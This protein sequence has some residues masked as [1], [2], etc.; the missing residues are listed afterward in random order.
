MSIFDA[1]RSDNRK[2]YQYE[3][4][5][6]SKDVG[7]VN[8]VV[9][10]FYQHD[11]TTFCVAQILGIYDLFFD[12]TT[13]NLGL[14]PGGWN[15]NPQVLCNAQQSTSKAAYG[16]FNFKATDKLTFTLGGRYTCLLYTS[17]AAD[18]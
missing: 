1:N 8:Y 12:Q 15:N 2:T 9:G 10:A 14:T 11:D 7:P 5:F 17:D 16:E 3:A 13:N 6:A 18:E 4:R